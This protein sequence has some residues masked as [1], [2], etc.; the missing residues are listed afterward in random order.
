MVEVPF[1]MPVEKRAQSTKGKLGAFLDALKS[2]SPSARAR[3]R[4]ER[5]AFLARRQERRDAWEQKAANP[6]A[7]VFTSDI[8]R[9]HQD[10]NPSLY[11]PF[12]AAR[13]RRAS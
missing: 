13:N 12:V 7:Y 6:G 2:L 3:A 10:A 5:E 9:V 4:A 11:A 1:R 8:D